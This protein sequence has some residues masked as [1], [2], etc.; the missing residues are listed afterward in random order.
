VAV[1]WLVLGVV[2][3]VIELRHLAF[4]LLFGAIGCLAAAIVAAVAPSAIP[5]QVAVAV[6]VAGAGV[7]TLRPF[8]SRAFAQR[9]EGHV[10]LGVHGGLVGQEAVTLDAVGEA[11]QVGHIGHVRLIGERWLATSGS[12][13][14]IPAGTKVLVTAIRGTTLVVWPVNGLGGISGEIES[15]DLSGPTDSDGTDGRT[16]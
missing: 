5:L 13:V 1:T 10:A 7:F 2:L 12:G 11:S 15:P 4:Y 6:V 9:H 16:T 8:V 14:T 3:F